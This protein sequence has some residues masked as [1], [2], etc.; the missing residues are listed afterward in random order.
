VDWV[1][2]HKG[3]NF[4]APFVERGLEDGEKR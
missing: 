3:F 4:D 1:R 2:A